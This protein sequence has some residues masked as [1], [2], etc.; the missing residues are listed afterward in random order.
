MVKVD[1][2]VGQLSVDPADELGELVITYECSLLF[3]EVLRLE[4]SVSSKVDCPISVSVID[5]VLRPCDAPGSNLTGP[6]VVV[7][8]VR[9]SDGLGQSQ[10]PAIADALRVR[11][12]YVSAS[13]ISAV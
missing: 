11:H 13:S 4:A 3:P 10:V 7:V 9:I 6:E 1:G 2:L 12:N 8:R 5:P